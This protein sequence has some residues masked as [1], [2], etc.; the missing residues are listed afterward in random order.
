MKSQVKRNPFPIVEAIAALVVVAGYIALAYM[1]AQ[2]QQSAAPKVDTQS[3][4]DPAPGGYQGLY[5]VLQRAGLRA[6][7]FER[8]AA[9]L[10]KSIDV[11][12][13][14]DVESDPMYRGVNGFDAADLEAISAWTK[15]GGTLILVGS[16]HGLDSSLK[17]AEIDSA[18]KGGDQAR[19]V[20]PTA[21]TAGVHSVAGTSVNRIPFSRSQ[22]QTPLLADR[23]GMVVATYR[24]GAGT[25]IIVTDPTLFQNRNLAHADNAR[26]AYDLLATS[27]GPRG[28]V[29][30]EEFSHGHRVGDTI[31]SVLPDPARAAL[32]IVCLAV[33]ALLVSTFF[34]FG[35]VVAQPNDDE[36]TSAEYLTSMAALLARGGAARKALRDVADAAIRG[37]AES[38]GLND[39]APVALLA[40]RLRG[41]SGGDEAAD[42]L[43]EL[44]RL[45]SYEYPKEADLLAAAR[46]AAMLR[47][48]YAP[49]ARIGFGRR[50]SP[51]KR[52]A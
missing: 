44:N 6:E 50:R 4:Y 40:E 1:Q 38:L 21:L 7:R 3:A 43:L 48:E 30:F 9:Y 49:H 37:L 36:R 17:M 5:E 20:I 2:Q 24:L 12:V 29:A 22:R 39:N 47:K 11:L 51:A 45:R 46:I 8:H 18:G 10:D 19:P 25:V 14:S 33:L 28:T 15:G 31:W 35:P 42:T 34:R 27:A 16:D 23:F 26:L 32:V 52:S 13:V 41:R